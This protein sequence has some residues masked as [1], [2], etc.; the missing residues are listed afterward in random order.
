MNICQLFNI[1]K[2]TNYLGGLI[3]YLILALSCNQTGVDLSFHPPQNSRYRVKFSTEGKV[4]MTIAAK[5]IDTELK[6]EISGRISF[7][8]LKPD[9]YGFRFSYDDYNIQQ[10]ANDTN[11]N[12]ATPQEGDSSDLKKQFSFIRDIEFTG[13]FNEMGKTAKLDGGDRFLVMLDSIW[14]PLPEALRLQLASTI[15]PLLSNDMVK[16]MVEQCFYV[17]PGKKVKVG[18]TWK[19]QINMRSFFSMIMH[20]EYKLLSIKDGIAE[21]SLQSIVN[22]GSDQ[23]L[24]PGLAM[25]AP[26]AFSQPKAANHGLDLLGL[27]LKAEFEGTQLG[28]VWVNIQTGLVQH[29][30]IKQDLSGKIHLS[31]L[32]MPMTMQMTNRYKV[33]EMAH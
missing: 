7:D 26:K 27:N 11:L 22:P 29:I 20:N 10:L 24:M 8:S 16:G 1:M 21:L 5:K 15:R 17:L 33:V 23:I 13:K 30:E 2:K 32:E 31:V 12:K 18:D 25:A 6:S 4:G 9:E 14:K 28:K 3:I 19:N